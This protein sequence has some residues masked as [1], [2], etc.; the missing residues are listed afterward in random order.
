MEMWDE[1]D[2]CYI[3]NQWKGWR[4]QRLSIWPS[5]LLVTWYQYLPPVTLQNKTSVIVPAMKERMKK[6]FN[7]VHKAVL[8]CE[9][10]D[11]WKGCELFY[12]LLDRRVCDFSF[13]SQDTQMM[14][15][16]LSWLLSPH[17]T[18]DHHMYLPSASVSPPDIT[19]VLHNSGKT[20]SLCLTMHGRTRGVMGLHWCWRD[21]EGLR[22]YTR[23]SYDQNGLSECYI[24]PEPICAI[25]IW[26][27]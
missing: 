24:T 27:I 7:E 13:Q 4:R 15:S 17:Y 6:A 20:D 21:R 22:W 2:V 25:S 9:D 8:A 26:I 16:G 3:I 11:G 10:T 23:P 12:E 14:L 5:L 1:V 18:P 19:R